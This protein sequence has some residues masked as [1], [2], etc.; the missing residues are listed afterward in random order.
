MKKKTL[1]PST[2]LHVVIHQKTNT[3]ILAYYARSEE[4][5]EKESA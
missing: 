4:N 2:K 5:H 3:F 1:L